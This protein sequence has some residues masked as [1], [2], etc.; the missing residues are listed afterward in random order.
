[1]E[2]SAAGFVLAKDMHSKTMP[3]D[4]GVAMLIIMLKW[5]TSCLVA[6]LD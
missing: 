4:R 5:Y 6:M 3:D 2:G 1:M